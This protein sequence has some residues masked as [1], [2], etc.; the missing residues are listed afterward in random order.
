MTHKLHKSL[1]ALLFLTAGSFLLC[2]NEVNEELYFAEMQS[3]TQLQTLWRNICEQQI[4]PHTAARELMLAG[5]FVTVPGG[6]AGLMHHLYYQLGILTHDRRSRWTPE[7]TNLC[8]ALLRCNALFRMLSNI[9]STPPSGIVLLGQSRSGRLP[10]C[11]SLPVK[12]ATASP[13]WQSSPGR[14]FQAAVIALPCRAWQQVT[15]AA[16]A[17]T[18]SDN[19][20]TYPVQL[21][22]IEYIYSNADKRFRILSRTAG[23]QPLNK[24]MQVYLLTIKLPPEMPP[25]LYQ[26]SVSC[27]AAGA[28]EPATL[29]YELEITPQNG[30]QNAL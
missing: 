12:G 9:N 3:Q 7:I 13:Q 18:G 11:D 30:G 15:P 22:K 19:I 2:G 28:P 17:L 21:Q 5:N 10:E 26:G 16:A 14:T 20:R 27:Q 4:S 29:K 1:I 25:G 24:G 8:T 23:E 6:F